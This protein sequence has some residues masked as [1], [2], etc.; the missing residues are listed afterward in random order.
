LTPAQVAE[1]LQVSRPTV[2]A[3]IERGEL[4]A[5]RMGLQSRIREREL[6]NLV[7]HR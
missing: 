6:A 7:A 2:Y 3:L 1:A 5:M 4:P